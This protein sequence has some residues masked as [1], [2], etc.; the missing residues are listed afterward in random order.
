MSLPMKHLYT[1]L[2][3]PMHTKC[4]K[5]DRVLYDTCV[6]LD[7]QKRFWKRMEESQREAVYK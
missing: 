1:L 2:A 6:L 7:L 5:T 3:W 4:C